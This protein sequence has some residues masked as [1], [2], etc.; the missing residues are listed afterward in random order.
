MNCKNCGAELPEGATFCGFCGT[1]VNAQPVEA[2]FNQQPAQTPVSEQP[3]AIPTASEY[4]QPDFQQMNQLTQKKPKKKKKALLIIGIILGVL[5]IIAAVL[6]AFRYQLLRAVIGEANYYALIETK[7]VGEFLK[8]DEFAEIL[9]VD[10][11]NLKANATQAYENEVFANIELNAAFDKS[12]NTGTG[13]YKSTPQGEYS[14]GKS[15]TY[16]ADYGNGKLGISDPGTTDKTVTIKADSVTQFDFKAVSDIVKKVYP[17]IKNVEKTTAKDKITVTSEDVDGKSCRVVSITLS[18]G[19][20][21]NIAADFLEAISKDKELVET[22]K[23]LIADNEKSLSGFLKYFDSDIESINKEIDEA[24]QNLPETVKKLRQ[25]A[26]TYKDGDTFTYKIAYKNNTEILQRQFIL[27]EE[28]VTVK[29]EIEGRNRTLTVTPEYKGEE[30]GK[31]T[32]KKVEAGDKLLVTADYVEDDET[33][34]HAEITDLTIASVNGV[35]VPVGKISFKTRDEGLTGT[36]TMT[37]AD[38]YTAE[39]KLGEGE[40]V[41]VT[42]N[43]TAELSDKADLSAYTE[44]DDKASDDFDEFMEA[45]NTALYGEIEDYDFD[46]SGDYDFEDDADYGFDESGDYEDFNFDDFEETTEAES[47]PQG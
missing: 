11:F 13:S 3:A 21:Y 20:C 23:K 6:F 5:L 36:V 17:I 38:K 14:D 39:I 1:P 4:A 10:S 43:I 18:E 47:L 32:Y 22:V 37:A 9:D 45:V 19:D 27:D 7:T 35:K 25:D 8:D 42:Y 16:K 12:K 29:T 24:I 15:L 30:E 34:F 41:Y 44:P 40:E 28:V 26:L 33:A 46:E 2:T 31:F